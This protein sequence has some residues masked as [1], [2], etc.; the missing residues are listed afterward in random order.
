[1]TEAE[2]LKVENLGRTTL[3]EIKKRLGEFGLQLGMDVPEA[4]SK[5][6]T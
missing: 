6:G 1:M 3:N 2:L 5:V 4:A